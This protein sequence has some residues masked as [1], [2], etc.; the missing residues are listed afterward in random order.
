MIINTIECIPAS[1]KT[2]AILTHIKDTKSKAMI[3]SISMMLSKQSYEYYL[4]IGGTKAAIIDSDHK[5]KKTNNDSLRHIIEHADVIFITH[6][7]L[8]N[9]TEHELFKEYDLYI[10]EVPELVSFD[11]FKFNSHLD[12]VAKYCKPFSKKIGVLSTLELKQECRGEVEKIALD[13]RNRTD[14]IAEY[15]FPLYSALLREIP[16][17]IQVSEHGF[18]CFFI[19]DVDVTQWN[20]KSVTIASSN[21]KDTLTGKTLKY[22]AGV[23]FVDSPLQKLV[24]FKQYTNTDRI[25]INVMFDG[26]WSRYSGDTIVNGKSIYNQIKT[27]LEDKLKGKQYIYCTNTY[28]SKFSSG[29]EINY[30]PHGLNMYSD[31]TNV[32]ALFSYNPQPWLVT[33]LSEIA[34]SSGLP[35]S[36]L[37]DAF[38]TSKYLEPAFQL[39]ARS[40]IRHNNSKKEINLFIPDI[41]L[42]MYMKNRYFPDANIVECNKIQRKKR[43]SFQSMFDMNDKE[44]NAFKK[45]KSRN[46]LSIDVE[47]D[48]KVVENWIN[49]YRNK[50]A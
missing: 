48:I 47:S 34:K 50:R 42:A 22:F 18:Q 15:L 45:Y 40:D 3:A 24:D 36:E 11:S 44:K 35:Q 32:I 9:I 38:I 17:K 39:C 28:R 30:N 10:D 16:V 1:G 26:D 2:K 7:A 43:R 13:G 6:A 8:L 12:Y 4:S 5:I 23:D 25:N 41:R 29:Q 14:D 46:N 31:Y 19:N 37:V 21:I 27:T 33:I 20:F 49:N